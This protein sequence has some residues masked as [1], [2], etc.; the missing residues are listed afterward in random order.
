MHGEICVITIML[1]GVF[2]SNNFI[3]GVLIM[4]V[5]GKNMMCVVAKLK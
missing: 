5:G 2:F 4:G 1:N 3:I